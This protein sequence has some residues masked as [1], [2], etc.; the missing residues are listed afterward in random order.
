MVEIG[1]ALWRE[2][3]RK[4]TSGLIQIRFSNALSLWIIAV[5]FHFKK[6]EMI[7]QTVTERYMFYEGNLLYIS[8]TTAVREKGEGTWNFC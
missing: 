1:G 3:H 6:S 2:K 4:E 8:S 7:P 5:F